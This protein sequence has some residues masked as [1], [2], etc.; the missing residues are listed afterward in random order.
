MNTFNSWQWQLANRVTT[1][2]SLAEYITVDEKLAQDISTAE[3]RFK[4]AITPYYASLMDKHDPNCPIRMQAIPSIAETCDIGSPDPLHE[5]NQ[6]PTPGLIHRYPDRVALTASSEC[7]MYCRHCTRKRFV[8]QPVQRTSWSSIQAGIEYIA[9]HEQI[10]D[11]LITGGDPLILSNDRLERII[12]TIRAI[13]HVEI[14]RIGTRVPCTLPQRITDDLCEMLQK[15]HPIWINTQFN[16]PKEL[17]EEA[18]A[19]VD[20]LIRAGIPVGNQSVL[21]RG[22]NDNLETM[23][24]L[25]HG[26]LKMRV[27]PYYLYQC[28]RL[29][30][31][32]HFW[33]PLKTGLELIEHLQGYTTGFAVPQFIVDSPIGKIPL[34]YSKLIELSDDHAIL[35]N[36]EGKVFRIEC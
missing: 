24:Q 13:A 10:R 6:S 4:W 34:S 1:V 2:T 25:L 30:G 17:T 31:T 27:R 33:T 9:R 18:A 5:E 20:K 14:I 21:L 26:L 16:H 32:S 12:Q 15:Y 7:A 3:K 11:V 36:Y 23:K 22:V 29:I 35:R 28:D 19:A 8:G